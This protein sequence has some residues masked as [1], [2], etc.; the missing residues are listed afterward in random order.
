MGGW[1]RRITFYDKHRRDA[2]A[3]LGAAKARLE[4][5]ELLC[6][7]GEML[8]AFLRP[9]LEEVARPRLAQRTYDSYAVIVERH[10]IPGLEHFKL[11]WLSPLDV[12]RF[13]NEQGAFALLRTVAYHRA[14]LRVALN[15]ALAWEF[16]AR[17]VAKL[18]EPAQAGQV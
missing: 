13:L 14:V 11:A 5:G 2:I 6:T 16:V 4:R 8:A 17:N 3:T 7:S 12:Q 9:W 10:L 18:A 15:Y 1:H